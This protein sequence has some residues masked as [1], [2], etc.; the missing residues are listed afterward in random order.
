MDA[1]FFFGLA[2]GVYGDAM[3]LG[4]MPDSKPQSAGEV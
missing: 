2:A 4:E 1:G 3:R